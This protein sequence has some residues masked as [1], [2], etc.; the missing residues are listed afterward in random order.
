MIVAPMLA[1][2]A[3]VTGCA[4][5]DGLMTSVQMPATG[6]AGQPPSDPQAVAAPPI[7]PGL[8]SAEP[9]K[10]VVNGQERAYLDALGAAGVRPSSDLL[11]LSIGSYVCQARAAHQS[12]QAIWDYVYPLVHSDVRNAHL[13]ATAPTDKDV[14]AATDSYIRIATERLC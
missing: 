2:T 10:L 14:D 9:G 13:N 1:T 7:G 5:T 8:S 3:L 6:G 11:A 4:A 12:P